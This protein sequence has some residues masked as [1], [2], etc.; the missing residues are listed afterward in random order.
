MINAYAVQ[1]PNGLLQPLR[2]DPG[3]LGSDEI[4][5][6]VKYC[7]VCHS[8]L[9]LMK[10]EWG[11]SQYPLVPGH[12]VAG[13]VAAVGSQVS[14]VSQLS[15]GS[16]GSQDSQDSQGSQGSPRI[17][18]DPRLCRLHLLEKGRPHNGPDKKHYKKQ[19]VHL[20][21][22]QQKASGPFTKSKT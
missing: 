11:I 20:Q 22:A 19:V 17:S 9:S 5:I 1:E 21:K 18:K 13:I 8:D 12:E 7:G 16:Q 4:E 6:D 10:N 14:H 3:E 15:Q 2:Y